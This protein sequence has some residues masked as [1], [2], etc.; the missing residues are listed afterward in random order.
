MFSKIPLPP[1]HRPAVFSCTP[2][3]SWRRRPPPVSAKRSWSASGPL[4]ASPEPPFTSLLL[5]QH[6]PTSL[7]TRG[8][9]PGRLYP[10]REGDQRLPTDR[11]TTPVLL[12]RP[13][14]SNTSCL[15]PFMRPVLRFFWERPRYQPHFM[16]AGPV[17]VIAFAPLLPYPGPCSAPGQTYTLFTI[18]AN[19]EPRDRAVSSGPWSSYDV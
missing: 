4:V 11:H 18:A 6:R 1:G 15:S 2:A 7:A 10:A 13:G 8:L 9:I 14:P 16:L 17:L 5:V 3:A 19:T 12:S